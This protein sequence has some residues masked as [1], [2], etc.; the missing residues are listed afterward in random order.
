MGTKCGKT[1]P[2]RSN[3]QNRAL[4]LLFTMLAEELNTSGLDMKRVFERKPEV[5]IP[6]DTEAVKKYL[7]KP[8]QKAQL[9]K[10]STTQL[11]TVEI[12][13]VFDTLNR[14]LGEAFGISMDFPS[15]ETILENIETHLT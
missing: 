1:Y 3:A 13:K 14:F 10:E 2:K 7:W 9:S 11:S 8:I 5:A 15:V 12:D 6:W 4:H